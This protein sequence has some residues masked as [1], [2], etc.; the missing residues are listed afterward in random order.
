MARGSYHKETAVSQPTTEEISLVDAFP[1][2]V[3]M[4]ASPTL[5]QG[6]YPQLLDREMSQS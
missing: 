3:Y 2:L 6:L 1:R 4:S 5:S